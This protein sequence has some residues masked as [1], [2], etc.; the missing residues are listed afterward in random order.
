VV[1][2][3]LLEELTQ[4]LLVQT[5]FFQLLLLPVVVLEHLLGLLPLVVMAVQGAGVL[6]AVPV[7]LVILQPHRLRVVMAHQPHPVKVVTEVVVVVQPQVTVQAG[8]VVL[9]LLVEMAQVRLVVMAAQELHRLF[10][11]LQQ[12]ILVAVVAVRNLQI[13]LELVDQAVAAQVQQ[14]LRQHQVRLIQVA[15]AEAVVL[16]QQEPDTQAAQAVQASSS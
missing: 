16:F 14:T 15:E 4:A 7:A 6:L 3:E 5:Q 9:L 10:L 2:A 8:V 1:L 12:H 11:V 13:L